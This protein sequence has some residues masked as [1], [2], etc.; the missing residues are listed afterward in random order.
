M[1]ILIITPAFIPSEFGGVKI[2]S[3]YLSKELVKR[4]HKVTVC[5][6]NACNM[7]KNLD[8]L[9]A[10]IVDGVYVIYFKNY[11]TNKHFFQF[12]FPQLASYLKKNLKKY[13]I[14]HMHDIRTFQSSIAYHYSKK[15]NVPYIISPHGSLP[16]INNKIFI[17][18]IYDYLIGYKILRDASKVIA[19]T[20][21][22][23][24]HCKEI[25][26]KEE[27]IVQISNAIGLN[28]YSELPRRGL[29]RSK[30]NISNEENIILFLGRI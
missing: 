13:D 8:R 29:F 7:S 20:P 11:A 26:L 6:S 5:T 24:K 4:G 18:K 28:E 21:T 17:K 15:Y 19:L 3:Y 27:K 16:K 10:Y 2:E 22:E 1:K 25:G 23:V 12:L 30:Y 9:G 14:V